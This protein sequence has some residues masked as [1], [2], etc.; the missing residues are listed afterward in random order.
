MQTI[1]HIEG[2]KVHSLAGIRCLA[3]VVCYC[4]CV[5][6]TSSNMT[7]VIYYIIAPVIL[8]SVKEKGAT[9]LLIMFPHQ[10]FIFRESRAFYITS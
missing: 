10:K 7:Y 6:T 2:E 9:A 5:I 4:Y 8:V 1:P 3:R